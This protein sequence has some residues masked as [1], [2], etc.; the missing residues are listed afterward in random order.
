M[1][2]EKIGFVSNRILTADQLNHMEDGIE[3]NG[4][5]TDPGAYQQMV[6]DGNGNWTTTERL[7][8]E[9]VSENIVV[10]KHTFEQSEAGVYNTGFSPIS[11]ETYRVEYDGNEYLLIG[12]NMQ[13][14]DDIFVPCLGEENGSYYQ[15]DKSIRNVSAGTHTI[16]ITQVKTTISYV[17]TKFIDMSKFVGKFGIGLHSEIFNGTDNIASGQYS[18]AE[19]VRT[20]ATG[21]YAHA[22]GQATTASGY[23]SHAECSRTKASG[24]YSHA[25]G[26]TTIASGMCSHA[27]GSHCKATSGNSHAEGDGTIA[28]SGPQHVQGQYNIEDTDGVYAHI[29]GNGLYNSNRSNAH[30]LDWNGNAWYA[31]TVEGIGMII[32]SSTPNSVKRFLIT[33]DDSGAISATEITQ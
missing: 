33:V 26:Y 4:L 8:W 6:T 18:H 25:E 15:Q 7:A 9:T 27:E 22:E 21:D 5:P 32:K 16:A 3:K 29:V 12:Y 11:G 30:T 31:G 19:G 28:T 13:I 1:S 14:F 10:E 23:A 20:E 24:S 17:P 2:Y